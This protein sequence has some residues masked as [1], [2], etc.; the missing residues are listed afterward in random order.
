M[1]GRSAAVAKTA[2]TRSAVLRQTAALQA[3]SRV[4]RQGESRPSFSVAV[5][6]LAA[7]AASATALAVSSPGLRCE[8]TSA[9]QGHIKVTTYNLLAPKLS[10]AAH[11]PECPPGCTEQENRFPKIVAR[12]D[13]WTKGKEIIGLQEVD[14]LWAGQLHAYFAERGYVAV[15]AQYGKE[16]NNYMGVMLA[17]P[18]DVY[19]TLDVDISRISDTAPAETWP[20]S[21]KPWAMGLAPFGWLTWR[22]LKD[23]L[24]CPPPDSPKDIVNF[25]WET[26]KSRMN[27]SVMVRLKPRGT[28]LPSFCVAT[29]HMPCLF[30]P[31]E[32]VRVVN[33]HIYLLLA[34]LKA[35]SKD[36][37]AVL[38][39][40]FNIKPFDSPY[41]LLSSGGDFQAAAKLNAAEVEGLEERLKASAPWKSGLTS[42]YKAYHS[43]EP[44]FT[45]FAQTVGMNTPFVET[46]DYIWVTPNL[47]E[48][49]SCPAAPKTKEE[50]KGPFP[51]EKEPSDHIPLSATL[52]LKKASPTSKL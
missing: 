49:V 21:K 1:L 46:L 31:P 50:V 23:V 18:R 39:G 44:L 2:L 30:G 20:K 48:V 13:E 15:F 22:G 10:N 41:A 17:W 43:A 36:S 32:K 25:E 33:I 8:S 4:H 27:E 14:L 40:D 9:K 19:E 45:N 28:D 24:G 26:A 5:G 35:F 7:A 38:M 29:Y 47:L 16:F 51:N 3:V 11:F 6:A 52:K 37:P 34:K 42:A 12:L